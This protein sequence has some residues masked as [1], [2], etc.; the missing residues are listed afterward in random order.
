MGEVR[1]SIRTNVGVVRLSEDELEQ[2]SVFHRVLFM[3]ILQIVVDSAVYDLESKVNDYYVVP[4]KQRKLRT[5]LVDETSFVKEYE[6]LKMIKC[7]F[8]LFLLHR[9]Q[10]VRN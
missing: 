5:V 7:Y 1:V 9:W 8:Y 4:L 6:K 3:K 10:Y 2:I